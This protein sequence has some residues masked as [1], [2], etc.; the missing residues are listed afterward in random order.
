MKQKHNKNWYLWI[1]KDKETN[2]GV[3]IFLKHFYDKG[4]HKWL[5][6]HWCLV[7]LGS[8]RKSDMDGFNPY[9]N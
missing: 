3:E 9:E 6:T 4:L 2:Y 8:C 5:R 1:Y 7:V